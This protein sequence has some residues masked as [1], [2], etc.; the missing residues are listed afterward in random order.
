MSLAWMLGGAVSDGTG[1]LTACCS[2][3]AAGVEARVRTSPDAP[4]GVGVRIRLACDDSGSGRE[5]LDG[6]VT[7][8]A[9]A[10]GVAVDA[11]WWRPHQMQASAVSGFGNCHLGQVAIAREPPP[12]ARTIV[13]IP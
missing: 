2:A 3:S 12:L 13:H 11:N 7:G 6:D 9:T 8:A 10:T 1:V 5:S 4:R